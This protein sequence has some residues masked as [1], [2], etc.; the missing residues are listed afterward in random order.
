M[1]ERMASMPICPVLSLDHTFNV[2]ARQ[3]VY[4][5]ETKRYDK[6]DATSC[7]FILGADGVIYDC[8]TTKTTGATEVKAALQ[9]IKDRY[10]LEPLCFLLH[11]FFLMHKFLASFDTPF[12]P[13]MSFL[14][15]IIS[16]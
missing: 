11:K 15:N 10:M 7:L 12:L 2:Q 13:L 5:P 16:T 1:T 3:G 9:R 4:N 8:S 6:V 14:R